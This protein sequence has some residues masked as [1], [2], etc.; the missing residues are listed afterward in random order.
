METLL[1]QSFEFARITPY[2]NYCDLS[3]RRNSFNTFND[4]IDELDDGDVLNEIKSLTVLY[5]NVSD[6]QGSIIRLREKNPKKN[7]KYFYSEGEFDEK[8]QLNYAYKNPKVNTNTLLT[9]D[10]ETILKYFPD[11]FSEVM[12]VTLNRSV[13]VHDDKVT[14]KIYKQEKVRNI[15]NKFY[16]KRMVVFSITFDKNFN[17][18][19]ASIE[20]TTTLDRKFFTKNSFKKLEDIVTKNYGLFKIRDNY[21]PTYEEE[22][23][24]EYTTI[25]NDEILYETIFKVLGITIDGQIDKYSIYSAIVCKFV[26]RKGIKVP[27]EF[28]DLMTNFYPTQKFLKKNQN[29]LIASI[30][31]YYGLKS[32]ST[33]KLFHTIP[34]VDIDFFTE[35]CYLLGDNYS[36]FIGNLNH[37]LFN[38]KLKTELHSKNKKSLFHKSAYKKESKTTTNYSLIEHKEK[39]HLI[40]I[41]NSMSLLENTDRFLQDFKDHIDMIRKIRQYDPNLEMNAKT[42]SEFHNEHREFSKIISS[43]KKGWVT[44]YTFNEKM[45]KDMEIPIDV[46]KDEQTVTLYPLILKR[47][48]EYQEE[49]SFMHHCVATYANKDIS[50]IIS[51]R[52]IDGSDRVTSEFKTQNG[53]KIQSRHFCNGIPPEYFN[54]ALQIISEKADKYARLGMLNSISVNK[55]RAKINGVEIRTDLDIPPVEQVFGRLPQ[56]GEVLPV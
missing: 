49:G 17:F 27:N 52:T 34:D 37:E 29:K 54:S 3:E 43:I 45:V 26:E 7:S 30:L 14:I 50:I 20:K 6:K 10:R 48:D 16:R 44:E 41:L 12:L 25:F 24:N 35:V 9:N 55:V 33:I 38:L 8:I 21:I 39:E 36:K 5:T 23:Y 11:P 31:D 32:K 56:F 28:F 46:I 13:R 19:T 15:F 1:E 4:E 18:T 2:K 53:N 51:L 22:L 40:Q 47:E 42:Y